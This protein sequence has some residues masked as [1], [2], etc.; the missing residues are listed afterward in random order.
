MY[1]KQIQRLIQLFSQFPTV[2]QRTAARFVFHILKAPKGDVKEIIEAIAQLRN[3]VA[4]CKMCFSPFDASQKTGEVCVICQDATRD[5]K[6]LCV[7]EKESDLEALESIKEYKGLYFILGGAVDPLQK[8]QRD[9]LRTKELKE[10]LQHSP[11]KEVIIATNP[12][13]E[14]EV[15]ALYVERVLK[16]MDVKLTRLGRGLPIGGE[17]E[18]ADPETLKQSLENRR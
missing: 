9:T 13:T 3:E 10:R 18:Y 15:T 16:D 14:G 11:I 12:T 2:G 7:V 4:L 8:E 5:Q 1:P 17:L 6:I